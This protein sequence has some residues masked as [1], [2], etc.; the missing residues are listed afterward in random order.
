MKIARI[1]IPVLSIIMVMFCL[2][3]I[4]GTSRENAKAREEFELVKAERDHK[5]NDYITDT[6]RVTTNDAMYHS[7]EVNGKMMGRLNAFN[8]IKSSCYRYNT[9]NLDVDVIVK[10]CQLIH[11]VGHV[12]YLAELSEPS[13]WYKEK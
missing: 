3:E 7:F 13:E 8:I 5:I 9:D 2:F 10:N 11:G 12:R 6:I 1:V 4:V